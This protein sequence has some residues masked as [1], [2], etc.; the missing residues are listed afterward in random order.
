METTWRPQAGPQKALIDAPFGEIL[1]GGARGGGKTDGVL[2]KFGLKEARFG[3]GFNGVFFRREMPQADDLIERAK[4]IYLPTGAEWREQSKTFLMPHG[5]R[6]RFRPLES[7]ADAAKYQ[8]QNL[9][10]AAV[11]EAGNYPSSAPIDMLFG[12]LRSTKGVPI[13]LILTANPGGVGHQWIKARYID[14]APF[15]KKALTR[16]MPTGK[17][18]HKFI[19]IPSRVSD[20]RLM[21]SKDPG[22]VDRLALTGSKELVKAWLD[23]DWNV[24]AGAFFPEFDLRRHVIAPRELPEHWFRFRSLDWGSA[25]PFSVGWWAVSDGELP[26]IPRGALVRYREW[27]GSTGKPNEGL[28]MTAEEVALGIAQ[29]EAGDPKPENGL[30]GV[31]DPAIFSS[32]GGPSIGERMARSAKVFFRPADNARVSRQGAL[33]GWDQVRAR[34]RGDETGPG[35]LIFSTCRDLIRTLPALQHDPDRPED[36]DSDGEDHAPDELRYA[37]MS[38]PW[39]RQKPVQKPGNI[40]SVGAANTATFNDLWKTAPRASRW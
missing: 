34:L 2:G 21:L 7:I 13:Q 3:S 20:N 33:G 10:D 29:R 39:V 27:Y 25:K 38:R 4:E 30:H 19:Y 16:L 24:I 37:C 32:D 6:L 18:S 5:G 17:Q 12:A 31:A 15:G 8:G 9:S 1:F 35:L 11:E 23:G 26:D 28:R 40:V 14:P 22:Y 36:V